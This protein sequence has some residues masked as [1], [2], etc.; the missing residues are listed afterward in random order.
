MAQQSIV[1]HA[2]A[3]KGQTCNWCFT[4][5]NWQEDDQERLKKLFE[6]DICVYIVWGREVGEEGTPHLQ[7]FVQFENKQRF[8]Q[9]QKMIPGAHLSRARLPDEAAE[10]CKK[11]GD[12]TECGEKRTRGKRDELQLFKLDVQKGML[13]AK[14][15]REKHSNVMARYRSF[16]AEY[17]MDNI[18]VTPQEHHPLREWQQNLYVHLLKPPNR[19]EI[20]FV[21]DKTGNNGKTWFAHYFAELIDNVQVIVPGKKADMAYILNQR[22]TYFFFDAPRSK[23]GEFIQ[24]DFLEELKNGYVLSP[25]YESR[26]K[27]FQMCHVVVLTNEMPDMTK[28]SADR[29]NIIQL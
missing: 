4:V 16:A 13:D 21:V 23:Q 12:Y 14:D 9:V 24:Y 25:K 27:T 3:N 8:K 5:N 7:G 18:K 10:Y 26:M 2:T 22:M 1:D 17:V 6:D 11:D 19:R 20:I 28:L 29:Y 15:L